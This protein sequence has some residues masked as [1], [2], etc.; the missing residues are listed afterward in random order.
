MRARDDDDGWGAAAASLAGR[1][2]AEGRSLVR[3]V[4]RSSVDTFQ[5]AR[6]ART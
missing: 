5:R 2:V 1:L 6:G 4:G 3:K